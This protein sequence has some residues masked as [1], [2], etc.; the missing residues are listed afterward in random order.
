MVHSITTSFNAN[1]HETCD[2]SRSLPSLSIHDLPAMP[3]THLKILGR[4]PNQL[5]HA[6]TR[7]HQ[8]DARIENSHFPPDG[9][10]LYQEVEPSA[11]F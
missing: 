1:L 4:F 10:T 5:N 9:V 2:S 3:S 6:S 11:R 8:D 7:S